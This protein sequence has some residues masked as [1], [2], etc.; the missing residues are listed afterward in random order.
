MPFPHCWV[1]LSK[2]SAGLVSEGT[3]VVLTVL[4]D[5]KGTANAVLTAWRKPSIERQVAIGSLWK[6]DVVAVA[7]AW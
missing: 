1:L 4:T 7:T 6:H 5:A 3:P 2:H